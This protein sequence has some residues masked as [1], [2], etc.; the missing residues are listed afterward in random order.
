M[1]VQQENKGLFY[2]FIRGIEVAGNKLPHPFYLFS[3]LIVVAFVLSAIFAGASATYTKAATSAGKDASEMTVVIKNLFNKDTITYVTQNMYKIYYAFSPMTMM[4]LLMLSIG[5]CEQVGMFGAFIKKTIAGAK[6]A[7]V[8]A[9][10]SFIAINA[11]TASN[12]GILGATAVAGAVFGSMGY[13]PWLGIILAYAAGNAGMS[14]N[15]FVGNLDV[16]ISGINESVC[17]PLGISTET[18]HV[19]EHWYFMGVCAL[20]LTVVFT[21]VTTKFVRGFSGEA[22]DLSLINVDT[23]H[24]ELTS[25]ER[26]GLR[27]AG[28][29]ALVYILALVAMCWPANSFFRAADGTIVPNSPLLKSVL[30]LLFL[31]FLVTGV[32]YG[33]AAGIIAKWNEV[34]KYLAKGIDSMVNFMVIALPASLFIYLFN[35]SNIPT[36]LGAAG[37][38]W[39]KAMGINGFALMVFIVFFSTFLNLFMTSGSAKWMILAPIL[40]PMLYA[41][42]FSPALTAVAYRI[43]DSATNAVAPISSDVAL[44]VGLLI[45]YNTDKDKTPGMGTVFAGCM[46]YAIATIIVELIILGVWW[47]FNIPLG[48][49]VT[50]FIGK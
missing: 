37:A 20:V 1:E 35:Q 31:F 12:A 50:M 18:V 46:P 17:G 4:G 42:G 34:P 11:N 9:V 44:I 25:E 23:S 13:N 10:V 33:R 21:W 48:P 14:A 26:R 6:P 19:L 41:V 32:A 24:K 49:G 7:V 40:I 36:Y 2:R 38:N 8:F 45:K 30:T 43:G 3:I 27:A 28:V 15:V 39:I 22:K 5:L 16:L 47:A 29:A